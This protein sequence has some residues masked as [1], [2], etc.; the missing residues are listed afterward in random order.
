MN[1]GGI[2]LVGQGVT[3]DTPKG[4]SLLDR[5]CNAGVAPA[6]RNIGVVYVTGN[7]VPADAA[8]GEEYFDRACQ[9]HLDKACTELTH[10]HRLSALQK[11]LPRLETECA[12][13][14]R[15]ACSRLGR[16]YAELDENVAPR[17]RPL[18]EKTCQLGVQEACADL[19]VVVAQGDPKGGLALAQSACATR[20]GHGC[21]ILGGMIQAG[22]GTPADD[23]RAAQ[24]YQRACDAHDAEGCI[25]LG[26]MLRNGSTAVPRNTPRARAAF[27][28]ACTA[29]DPMGCALIGT[30]LTFGEGG[31]TDKARGKTLLEKACA[32]SVEAACSILG[33]AVPKP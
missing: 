27:E 18:L 15:G 26:D 32:A 28:T 7:G 20:D 13:R 21:A 12:A 8:R 4:L 33:R 19:A 29:G 17:A 6:C 22:V 16:A 24:A 23:A 5:S 10:V 9:L 11:E 14:T 3:R 2:Y 25:A 30:M 31:P 1:L